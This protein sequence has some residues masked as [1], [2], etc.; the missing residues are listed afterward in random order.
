MTE[1][2]IYVFIDEYGTPELDYTKVGVTEFFVYAAIIIAEPFL[3]SARDIYHEIID[4]DFHGKY[5]KSKRIRNDERGFAKR[6]NVLSKLRSLDFYVETLVVDKKHIRQDGGLGYKQIFEKY[7]Q[8]ILLT[9]IKNAFDEVYVVFDK[10]GYPDFQRS[11]KSYMEQN[12]GLEP[13]L[14]SRNSYELK[15]DK[16]EEPLLQ[17]ADFY[18]GTIGRCLCSK[19]KML[20]HIVEILREHVFLN[21]FPIE[22]MPITVVLQNG[23]ENFDINILK[24]AQSSIVDYLNKKP[25]DE[26]ETAVAKLL[27]DDSITTPLRYISSGEIRRRLLYKGVQIGD[28]IRTISKLR[29]NGL[30]IVSPLSKRGYK[31]PTSIE[32]VKD[33]FNRMSN[34]VVPQLKRGFKFHQ[35]LTEKSV[36]KY[37]LWS[38]A[39]ELNLLHKL[40][41]LA[42]NQLQ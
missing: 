20:E 28:P 37:N 4:S 30:L 27:L 36:G 32:Q 5:I 22:Y 23:T 31:L 2:N 42:N 11:L 3:Q 13:T 34:N 15:D 40:I 6:A 8:K 16:T 38:D 33:F 7:F 18:A 14:F 25:T 10:T 17:F 39:E 1:R 41:D 19:E 26:A 24:I 35:K 12:V 21:W 9:P 29:D